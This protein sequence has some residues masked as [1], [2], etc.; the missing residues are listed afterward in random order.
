[1]K[2]P[3]VVIKNV[4]S[5]GSIWGIWGITYW[6]RLTGWNEFSVI[7]YYDSP[8]AEAIVVTAL[9]V[10]II[11]SILLI[12]WRRRFGDA[13]ALFVQLAAPGSSFS[14]LSPGVGAQYLVWLAPFIL[15]LSP[16]LFGYLLA[17]SSLFLFFFYNVITGGIPW[18]WGPSTTFNTVWTP[19]ALWPWAV[20]ITGM[21][22]LWKK[23][24]T[25]D[26]SLRLLSLAPIPTK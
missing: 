6:L 1:M 8:L 5:Y 7:T 9:K 10:I 24:R 22:L 17:T 15:V 21:I 19:W 23:A 14:F 12:A 11:L 16:V 3:L 20:L 4:F 2:F 26:P 18:Y 25:A 13:Q